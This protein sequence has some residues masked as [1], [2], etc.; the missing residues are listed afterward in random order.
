MD[1]QVLER[2]G[3]RAKTPNK[4]WGISFQ[5]K[6]EEGMIL[7]TELKSKSELTQ[8]VTSLQPKKTVVLENISQ[9]DLE[10]ILRKKLVDLDSRSTVLIISR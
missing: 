5:N 6:L 10:E 4:Y 2:A 9:K 3:Q 8:Y 1:I 7:K